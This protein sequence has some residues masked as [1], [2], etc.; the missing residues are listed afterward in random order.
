MLLL[1]SRIHSF[2]VYATDGEV[3]RILDFYF[4]VNDWRIRY[5]LVNTGGW[6]RERLAFIPPDGICGVN[7]QE[8]RIDLAIDKNHIEK[9]PP[10]ESREWF[11]ADFERR[12]HDHYSLPDSWTFGA[13]SAEAVKETL[14]P[15][16]ANQDLGFSRRDFGD[17]QWRRCDALRGHHVLATDGEIGHVEDFLVDVETWTIPL[18]VVETRNWLPGR[19][20]M[21]ETERIVET[22]SWH[23]G[24]VRVNLTRDQVRSAP[25]SP[26]D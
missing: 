5:I 6:L 3:G 13:V 4:G 23:H 9:S 21:M 24:E 19:H 8:E 26:S 18:L 14:P 22:V 16:V 1:L 10:P 11:S 15:E 7:R 2:D 17:I 25:K 20:V 12:F